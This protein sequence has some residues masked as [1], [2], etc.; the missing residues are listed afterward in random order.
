MPTTHTA[1]AGQLPL[2][3]GLPTLL[4]TWP[5]RGTL[6]HRALALL[7]D[8]SALDHPTF[9]ATTG[10]WRLAAVVFELR[11]LGW[12]VQSEELPAPTAD[13]ASRRIAQYRISARD[14]ADLLAIR[15]GAAQ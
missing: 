10:S 4:P 11:A 1:P 13:S 2:F 15:R 6:A 12:P 7:L 3:E 9:E 5:T 8:G 14:L